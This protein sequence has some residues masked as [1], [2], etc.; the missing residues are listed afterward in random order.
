[1]LFV[2][3]PF[4]T[5]SLLGVYRNLSVLCLCLCL[6]P[7]LCPLYLLVRM[8]SRYSL[9]PLFIEV[10]VRHPCQPHFRGI[11]TDKCSLPRQQSYL[12]TFIQ[13]PLFARPHTHIINTLILSFRG[14]DIDR[15]CLVFAIEFRFAGLFVDVVR[16]SCQSSSALPAVSPVYISPAF[17]SI[18]NPKE[19]DD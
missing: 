12:P 18:L 4:A 1:M 17:L 7:P 13:P 10:Y 8:V 16:S 15:P 11:P 19:D 14:S 6:S 5:R 9:V 3:S 2:H